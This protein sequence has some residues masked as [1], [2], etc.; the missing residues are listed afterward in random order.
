M[1]G[2][3]TRRRSTTCS[4]RSNGRRPLDP[5]ESACA[6]ECCAVDAEAADACDLCGRPGRLKR[7]NRIGL[8]AARKPIHDWLCDLCSN[9]PQA[10]GDDN[11]G[12]LT[13]LA[14]LRESIVAEIRGVAPRE[15]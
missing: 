14:V 2:A 1:T 15:D 12:L 13:A 8:S 6:E 4:T 9:V 10:W 11:A 5:D 7:W 3:P